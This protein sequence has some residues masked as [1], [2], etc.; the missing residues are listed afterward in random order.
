MR[1]NRNK[2]IRR[3][4]NIAN[5][6]TFLRSKT[7]S[8]TTTAKKVDLE[9]Q[10]NQAILRRRQR[11]YAVILFVLITVVLAVFFVFQYIA[12]VTTIQYDLTESSLT[13]ND[14][15]YRK[16]ANEYLA[17]HPSD[18]LDF[19]RQDENFSN[20]MIKNAPEIAAVDLEATP[21]LG[22]N[23]RITFRNPVAVWESPEG[24]Q[25]V[26][27]TGHIF[28]ENYMLEPSV[29][30]RDESGLNLEGAQ[31]VAPGSLLS[32]IGRVI[33]KIN[34]DPSVGQVENVVLPMG[35]IRYIELGI[36]GRPYA[37]KAQTDRDADSQAADIINILRYLDEKQIVPKNY[38]DARVKN[39]AYYK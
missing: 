2:T 14:E 29:V 18:R 23:L 35:A 37:I 15:K 19:L 22:G 26:D 10:K 6:D 31:T 38:V 20:F 24:R 7:I 21:F 3:R 36:A 30:I 4:A 32:F 28:A 13:V 34:S 8:D 27:S 39:K 16:L 11:F 17:A 1:K 5:K 33:S 12:N 9:R 25:Y